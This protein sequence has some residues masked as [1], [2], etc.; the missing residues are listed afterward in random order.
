MEK[1]FVSVGSWI[2]KV[3]GK[4]VTR[5]AEISSGLNKNGQPYELA[6]TESRETVEGTYPVGTIL[7]AQMTF[8]IS[9]HQEDSKSLKLGASASK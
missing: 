6:D 1:R 7:A 5:L 8:S 9:E 4:A 3:S 2:D